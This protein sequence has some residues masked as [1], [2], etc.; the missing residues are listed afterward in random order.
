MGII[1]ISRKPCSNEVF[2]IFLLYQVTFQN[3]CRF[4]K[5]LGLIGN[6][7]FI[8]IKINVQTI[9]FF[10]YFIYAC[11]LDCANIAVHDFILND[12]SQRIFSSYSPHLILLFFIY[13]TIYAPLKFNSSGKSLN[14]TLCAFFSNNFV[15][16]YKLSKFF[17]PNEI[18]RLSE[19]FYIQK[20]SLRKGTAQYEKITCNINGAAVMRLR[21]KIYTGDN[22]D[23]VLVGNRLIQQPPC[24]GNIYS[25]ARNAC[26][27]LLTVRTL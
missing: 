3:I 27:D 14:C 16:I 18:N 4:T 11:Y 19:L 17:T 23:S 6:L 20:Q 8:I 15:V 25:A 7:D 9:L 2:G 5:I 13:Y 12:L 24:G 1:N 22:G 26:A 10:C 21:K